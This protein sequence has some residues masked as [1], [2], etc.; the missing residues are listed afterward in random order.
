MKGSFTWKF[1]LIDSQ[2][3][4]KRNH[5]AHGNAL[6]VDCD[7]YLDLHDEISGLMT[8]FRNQLEN[9][10]VTREYLLHP[11]GADPA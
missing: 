2:L 6:V 3:L 7:G 9:A 10:A 5:I 1:H 4:A 8:L 11:S